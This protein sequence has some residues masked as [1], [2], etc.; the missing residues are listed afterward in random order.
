MFSSTIQWVS[1]CKCCIKASFKIQSL[2]PYSAVSNTRSHG[3][4]SRSPSLALR[5]LNLTRNGV[6]GFIYESTWDMINTFTAKMTSHDV[7]ETFHVCS[8]NKTFLASDKVFYFTLEKLDYSSSLRCQHIM[9]T[10]PGYKLILQ[11]LYYA[12]S[13]GYNSHFAHVYDGINSSIGVPWK[14]ESLHWKD[15]PVFNSSKSSIVFDLYKRYSI[16]LTIDFLAY[17]I[18]G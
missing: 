14:M 17:T 9:E 6:N 3:V 5:D 12:S 15:G 16:D 4:L 13:Y 18:K 8:E 1:A 11:E 7:Y 2:M 10:E